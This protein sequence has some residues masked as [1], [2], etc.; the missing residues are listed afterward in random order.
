MGVLVHR[1]LQ[2]EG[3]WCVQVPRTSIDERHVPWMSS[4]CFQLKHTDRTN[5]SGPLSPFTFSLRIERLE[6]ARRDGGSV[7]DGPI[8]RG[9]SQPVRD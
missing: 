6:K 8:E 7:Q 4:L 2:P 5:R 9:G 3:C 1:Q